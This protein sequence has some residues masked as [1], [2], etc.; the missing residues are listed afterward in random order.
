MP[1]IHAALPQGQD[2]A[3]LDQPQLDPVR[4]GPQAVALDSPALELRATTPV[5]V[6]GA[7]MKEYICLT[8]VWRMVIPLHLRTA[9]YCAL[10]QRRTSTPWAWQLAMAGNEVW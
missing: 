10:V 3:S 5:F 1:Q 7:L 2:M 8:Q 9:V 6:P 4:C